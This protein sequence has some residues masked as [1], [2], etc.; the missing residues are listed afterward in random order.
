MFDEL[1]VVAR[2]ADL[3]RDF[4]AARQQA[5]VAHIVAIQRLERRLALR[6]RALRS[7]LSH[8]DVAGLALSFAVDWPGS[9]A[10]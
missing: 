2:M 4:A 10:R 6:R 3:E 8:G 1:Y 5:A 9:P 7:A